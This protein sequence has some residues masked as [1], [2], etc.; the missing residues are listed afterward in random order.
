MLGTIPLAWTLL[1]LTLHLGFPSKSLTAPVLSPFL[2]L[3][4]LPSIK[5]WSSP[6]LSP[7]PSSH[8]V[9]CT[10]SYHYQSW[11]QLCDT[12]LHLQPR[13]DLC[14]PH[15]DVQ[16]FIYHI[17]IWKAFLFSLP[18]NKFMIFLSKPAPLPLFSVSINDTII[19]P[20]YIVLDALFSL[21]HHT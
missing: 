15:P 12:S 3:S 19:Q 5:Y 13:P 21:T 6:S 17:S 10:L 18:K 1:P 8:F 16:L 11:F 14:V 4:P 20:A 2:P 7:R 9:Y